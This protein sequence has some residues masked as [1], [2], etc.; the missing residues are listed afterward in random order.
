[1]GPKATDLILTAQVTPR[2]AARLAFERQRELVRKT[3][4][5]KRI[6]PMRDV[7][8]I[9]GDAIHRGLVTKSPV[10]AEWDISGGCQSPVYIDLVGRKHVVNGQYHSRDPQGGMY[11]LDLWAKC[12]RCVV[13]LRKRAHHWAKRAQ[14]EFGVAP[15]TWFATFTFRP[16][17]HQRLQMQATERL[18]SRCVQ[19]DL[20]NAEEQWQETIGEYGQELTKYWKRLRKNT[21]VKFRYVL[22]AEPHKNGF[23]HFHALIHE[24]DPSHQ[25]R[26]AELTLGWNLGYTKFKLVRDPKVAWYVAKYLSKSLA[27]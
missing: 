6:H 20:L 14:K 12:R 5:R 17:E 11:S 16:E 18:A 24:T 13:C 19:F 10:R 9:A 4:G 2:H 21:G 15:R 25:L 3:K 22:V 23:P 1:M 7:L 27:R 8:R 26:H